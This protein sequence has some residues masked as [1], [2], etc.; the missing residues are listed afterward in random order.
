M[1]NMNKNKIVFA[2]IMALSASA[3]WSQTPVSGLTSNEIIFG[4]AASFAGGDLA[5]GKQMRFGFE[6]QFRKINEEGGIYGKK[7]KMLE[8][9]DAGQAEKTAEGAEILLKK[10]DVFALLGTTGAK[11][12]KAVIPLLN[13]Y[14]TPLIGPYSGDVATSQE[15]NKYVF[16][17]Q[18]NYLDQTKALAEHAS[19][20]GIKTIGL[21]QEDVGDANLAQAIVDEFKKRGVL[22][23]IA[24]G[25]TSVT[26]N[27]MALQISNKIIEKKPQGLIV[28]GS[29]SKV[30]KTV[31]KIIE[32]IPGIQVYVIPTTDTL[33]FAKEMGSSSYGVITSQVVPMPFKGSSDL[34]AEY[35]GL[36]NKYYPK[37][38]V[39]FV[40]LQAYATAKLVS[41]ALKKTG[42]QPTK[43]K[44][45]TS[46][47]SLKFYNLGGIVVS[48]GQSQ[49]VGSKFV[50]T[51]MIGNGQNKENPKQWLDGSNFEN[52]LE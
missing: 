10:Y 23:T 48:Y 40:G 24:Q 33:Q 18:A 31:S 17:T 34:A 38:N 28:V 36:L 11:S 26:T 42:P 12:T 32:S 44:F 15:Y 4:R 37:E 2:A 3:G 6:A 49:R 19:Q 7:I 41:E 43:E 46:M 30:A 51:V 22:A 5:V 52:F 45:I 14:K 9:D 35:K 25:V 50:E 27:E 16:N 47:E 13:Q 20:S 29:T 21:I 39:T 8:Y 1:K